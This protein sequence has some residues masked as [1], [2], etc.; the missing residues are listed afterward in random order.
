MEPVRPLVDAYVLDWI[1]REPVGR[2]W[3][4]EQRDGNCRLMGSFAATLAETAP[5]WGRAVAPIA[6]WVTAELWSTTRKPNRLG[7]PAIRLTETRRREA[8]GVAANLPANTP[9]KPMR[10]CRGCGASVKRDRDYC[11]ACGLV[12][13]T[14]RI[15]EVGEAGRVAAQSAQAQASRAETQRRHTIAQH[16]WKSS[17]GITEEMYACEI[18]PHLS[19][20]SISA[21]ATALS[22]SWSYA[23]DIRRGRRRPHE[24]HWETLACLV[25]VEPDE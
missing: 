6:E 8:K 10:I 21:I 16:A 18:Q 13:S 17:N 4:F 5:T 12:I 11:T 24:R 15:L 20:L 3:F 14:Q 23:A 19:K 2:E 22:V 9:P 1:S 25:G 7:L